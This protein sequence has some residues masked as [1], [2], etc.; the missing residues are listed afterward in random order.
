[1]SDRG[2]HRPR[3][4]EPYYYGRRPEPTK[5]P[6]GSLMSQFVI[7]CMSCKSVNLRAVL[8]QEEETCEPKVF[9]VCPRCQ[10]REELR[11]R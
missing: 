8:E 2:W 4:G 7:S 3:M 6:A 10:V 9:L 5:A 11:L 1:M